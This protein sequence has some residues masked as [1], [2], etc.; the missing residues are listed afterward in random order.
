MDREDPILDQDSYD[1]MLFEYSPS[2]SVN[3]EIGQLPL[4]TV[5]TQ[6]TGKKA[7]S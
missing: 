7:S 3:Q 5:I 6:I 2:V 4:F 1:D